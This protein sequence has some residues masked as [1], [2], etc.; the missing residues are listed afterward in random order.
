MLVEDDNDAR[1]FYAEALE[2]RGYRVLV[3]THG[4]EGVS[5]ARRHHPDLILMDLRMPVMDGLSALRYLKAD[6]KTAP[7]PVWAIS[8]HFGEV[9]GDQPLL[10]RFDRRIRKP[11]SPDELISQIRDFF[12]PP[13]L[14]LPDLA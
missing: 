5:L 11:L 10:E 13:S 12:E 4:A 8:A 3:A 14:A 7:I 6:K 1:V 2:T 9:K